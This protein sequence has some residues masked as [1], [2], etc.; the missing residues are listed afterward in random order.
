MGRNVFH[1]MGAIKAELIPPHLG[2][3][4]EGW[5]KGLNRGE[6]TGAEMPQEARQTDVK[7]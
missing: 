1:R 3:G 6:E 2:G 7:K 4:A 5:T